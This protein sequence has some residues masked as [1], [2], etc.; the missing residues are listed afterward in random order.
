MRTSALL[1]FSIAGCATAPE[2]LLPTP[3]GSGPVVLVD[4]DAEPLPE[5]PYPNDLATRMDP[6]SPTGLRLNISTE[7]KTEDE[8][9]AREK[10]NGLTGF[11]IYAPLTVAFEAPLD[12]DN[13][14]DRHANDPNLGA[15]QYAD[16]AI[17]V[18]NVDPDSPDYLQ[19]VEL[20]I[21]DGRYPVTAANTRRYFDNDPYDDCTTATFN[22][23]DEDV[24]GN[25]QLDWGEDLDNDGILDKPNV[26]PD[27]GDIYADLL[28]FYERET[29]TL[30]FRPVVP[31]Q[32][33]TTYAVVLTSRLVGEDGQPIR[34]PW[35]YVNHTRQTEA[36]RPV[37]DAM[38]SLG[39]ATDEI[40]Y[41]W[42]FTTGR[43]TGDLVEIYQGLHGDGPQTYL[44]EQYPGGVDEALVLHDIEG[45]DPTN[46]DAG[47]LMD[48]LVEMGLFAEDDGIAA[49]YKAFAERL[50]GGSI[51]TPY[52][53]A[54][55]DGD[56]DGDEY[57]RQDPETGQWRSAPQ[58]VP[59]TCVIP[60]DP[61]NDPPNVALYGHGYGSS[62]FEGLTFLWAFNRMGM[63]A[64]I[65]DYPGHGPTIPQDELP[66]YEAL[67]NTRNLLPFLAHL[68]DSRYR[69]LNNDG[70]PDSGGDQ[71][72]ADAFH[73]RDMVRQ[74]VVDTMQFVR[75]LQ[76]CGEGEMQ[77][78]DGGTAV[79]CDWD[80]DGGPDLGGPDAS[81][82]AVG[83]S[84]GGI[85]M[86]VAAALMPEVS[87]WI[88]HVPG[89]GLLDVGGR[90]EIGGAIPAMQGRL[91]GPFI[92]GYPDEEE[93]G[94]LQ[95]SQVVNSVTDMV[96]VPFA[97]LDTIP[98]GGRIVVEN[99]HTG[100]LR[101]GYI[102]E[103]GRFRISIAANG[104]DPLEK[105]QLFGMTDEVLL[106][107]GQYISEDN[108]QLG[109]ELFVTIYD[110]DENLVAEIDTFAEQV[111]H[112]GVTMTAGSPLVA[113]THGLGHIKGSAAVRR[114]GMVFS[115]ILEPGD[116]IAYAP[117]YTEAPFEALGGM[118]SNVV[119]SPVIGDTIVPTSAGIAIARAAG[120]L[121]RNEV[122]ER[123]GVSVDQWMID[124]GV[125]EG[126]VQYSPYLCADGSQCLFDA[127]DLDNGEDVY[128]AESD[129]PLR[130]TLETESG[131]SAL[132]LP[133]I[134]PDGNHGITMPDPDT[135]FDQSFF[136]IMQFAS[137]FASDGKVLSDDP[138]LEDGSCEWIPPMPED[139]GGD[140]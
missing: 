103:D 34:S 108:S 121:E 57:W 64:C 116:P 50:V 47:H 30:I 132:R 120:W 55:Q 69:D 99:L 17:F 128:G 106:D 119:V 74:A 84:L 43:V 137:Y 110:R 101:E 19:P 115:A 129:E 93:E 29:N 35:E 92:M 52:L 73:T 20:D 7:A 102:P 72:S 39:V 70:V 80:G 75:S 56:G 51:T 78:P 61:T 49:N 54:D 1:L 130:V 65:F 36:L 3:D 27:G 48:T 127:D 5:I 66:L 2:G 136:T 25:G 37:L 98:A 113:V 33:E 38:E 138:C 135:P 140:Q 11:G 15:A 91:W 21:G 112:E 117:H 40:A 94:T 9:E 59:F 111:T 134:F 88:P 95:I 100:E 23:A 114:V 83:G 68:Q 77:L 53:L 16:D 45:E 107:G 22:C 76:Q 125:V 31:M 139:E 24:N 109:D 89:G 105:R 41:T 32:E 86:A 82:Y 79:S 13:I 131:V 90:S 85:N 104:L 63:A 97:T 46:L 18:V 67:L 123:Y 81:Y 124:R 133:Y 6:T 126:L 10:L 14:L 60:K 12:I 118:P 71:W 4:W 44:G 58:R 28:S 62:R 96:R 122:D 87:A 26:W 8:R 42:S